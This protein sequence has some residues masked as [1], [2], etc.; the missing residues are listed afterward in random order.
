[1]TGPNGLVL[2]KSQAGARCFFLNLQGMF[3]KSRTTLF[4]YTFAVVFDGICWVLFGL[5][6]S[7]SRS[8]PTAIYPTS[9]A[10]IRGT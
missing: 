5:W 2:A 9:L 3:L 10:Y 1:M 8:L 6:M 4:I 7:M